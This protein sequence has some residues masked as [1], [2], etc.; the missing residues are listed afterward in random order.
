MLDFSGESR[1]MW[2]PGNCTE[3]HGPPLFRASLC[4][5]LPR[6][7]G[8]GRQV[9]R[10]WA[11]GWNSIG[12]GRKH[13]EGT[14][15]KAAS[16]RSSISYPD[17]VNWV[18]A[19]PTLMH[20]GWHRNVSLK[21]FHTRPSFLH[22]SKRKRASI[23]FAKWCQAGILCTE[24]MWEP[25]SALGIAIE[26]AFA[27]GS[28]YVREAWTW[29]RFGQGDLSLV[30]V[31]LCTGEYVWICTWA[32]FYV[33]PIEDNLAG[34]SSSSP[35]SMWRVPPLQGHS[36]EPPQSFLPLYTRPAMAMISDDG[37]GLPLRVH[38]W[39][40]RAQDHPTPLNSMPMQ[41]QKSSPPQVGTC[42]AAA[43]AEL[44]GGKSLG[45]NGGLFSRQGGALC[46]WAEPERSLI[47]CAQPH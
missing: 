30:T 46:A 14:A 24:T 6:P 4:F 37:A 5:F 19:F 13:R 29:L 16:P 18:V 32:C 8:G 43:W 42:M 35:A 47:V 28:V 38:L 33:A 45:G 7:A 3:T 25:L 39:W 17:Q 2:L 21:S 1:R 10:R 31:C 36:S 23:V 44:L 15:I 11:Q 9:S 41:I 40:P 22:D 27:A 26:A 20:P 12:A 34:I